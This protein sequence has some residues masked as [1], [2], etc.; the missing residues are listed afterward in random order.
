M[1]ADEGACDGASSAGDQ[2]GSGGAGDPGR[3]PPGSGGPKGA[4]GEGTSA[5]G[6]PQVEGML[7][8]SARDGNARGQANQ[9][10]EFTLTVPFLSFLEAEVAR[11]S[12]TSEAFH[13]GG[14][15]E[16]AVSGSDLI[17]RLTADN[18]GDMQ[19]SIT[20]FLNQL[21]QVVRTMQHIGSRFF[22]KPQPGKGG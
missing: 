21:S 9:P 20:V 11:R 10:L 13:G 12:L 6:A 18:P 4:E 2:G 1:E 7:Q 17:V 5:G 3:R 14:R 15:K 8:V 22:R 16:L 19:T